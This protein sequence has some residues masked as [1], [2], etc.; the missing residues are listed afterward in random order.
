MTGEKEWTA[1][2]SLQGTTKDIPTELQGHLN[3]WKFEV[4]SLK[5]IDTSKIS[6]RD[7]KDCIEMSKEMFAG[8]YEGLMTKQNHQ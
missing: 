7:M 1:P 3:D 8:N 5:D 2:T 6:D 4:V